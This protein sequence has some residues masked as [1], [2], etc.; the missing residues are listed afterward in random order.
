MLK[1]CH[2]P[3]LASINNKHQWDGPHSQATRQNKTLKIIKHNS[4]DNNNCVGRTCIIKT[5]GRLL[6]QIK[7]DSQQQHLGWEG[8]EGSGGAGGAWLS[9]HNKPGGVSLSSSQ[10]IAYSDHLSVCLSLL[11]SF[12]RFI[13]LP[14]WSFVVPVHFMNDLSGYISF[15]LTII[16]YSACWSQKSAALEWGARHAHFTS[17]TDHFLVSLWIFYRGTLTK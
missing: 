1:W 16:S 17:Q 13:P 2:S 7:V 12:R 5:W 8:R 9:L 6:T 14:R 4:A 15:S 11:L 10:Y 3:P